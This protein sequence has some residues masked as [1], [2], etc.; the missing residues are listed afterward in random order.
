VF[1]PFGYLADD[2]PYDAYVPP[3]TTLPDEPMPDLT[4]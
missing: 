4:P 3:S 1:T 2:N